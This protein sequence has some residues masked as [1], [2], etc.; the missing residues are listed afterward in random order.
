MK[1]SA[2]TVRTPPRPPMKHL[3]PVRPPP[4]P[5]RHAAVPAHERSSFGAPPPPVTTS[6]ALPP[7]PVTTSRAL[8]PP[9]TTSRALPPP[10][11]PRSDAFHAAVPIS[12]HA[13]VSAAASNS[14]SPAFAQQVAQTPTDQLKTLASKLKMELVFARFSQNPARVADA[15]KKLNFVEGQM[16]QRQVK[17]ELVSR[18]QYKREVGGMSTEQIARSFLVPEATMAK[19]LVRAKH[20]IRA[21]GIPFRGDAGWDQLCQFYDQLGKYPRT[22]ELPNTIRAELKSYQRQGV[23][24]FQDLYQLRLGALLADDMGLGKTLQ[25]LAFLEDLRVKNEMGPVLVIVPSNSP[26]SGCFT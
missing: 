17:Q 15:Q 2:A 6:R 9:V 18:F 7:P 3:S 20:K 13:A 1:T 23:Q 19:R 5:P 26:F 24:W 4:P 16:H 11:P 22:L 21:A 10:P 14:V 25:T 8:P 12:S